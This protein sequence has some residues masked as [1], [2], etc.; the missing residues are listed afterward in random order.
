MIARFP[1]NYPGILPGPAHP[2]NL[3]HLPE[4]G[5]AIPYAWGAVNHGCHRERECA[6]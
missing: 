5:N 1:M 4:G 6:E 3:G 2:R